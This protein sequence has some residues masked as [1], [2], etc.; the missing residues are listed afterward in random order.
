MNFFEVKTYNSN[1]I[2]EQEVSRKINRLIKEE[3]DI[4]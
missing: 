2:L 3:V 1:K 4:T